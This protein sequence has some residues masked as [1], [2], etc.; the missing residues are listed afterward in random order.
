MKRDMLN[1]TL[2]TTSAGTVTMR[3]PF[4]RMMLCSALTLHSAVD[5]KSACSGR[6]APPGPSDQTTTVQ[7][8]HRPQFKATTGGDG[9]FTIAC[10]STHVVGPTTGSGG[11]DT[12]PATAALNCG[13]QHWLDHT[14][15][16]HCRPRQSYATTGGGGKFTT[17]GVRTHVVGPATGNGG[18]DMVPATAALNC[19]RQHWL[20]HTSR[21]HCRPRDRPGQGRA[22]T[23]GTKQRAGGKTAARGAAF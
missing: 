4:L 15:R 18:V 21:Q 16:Q 22:D 2:T 7:G 1:N 12:V 17:A 14:S 23:I 6:S 5:A 9:N 10:V 11:V 19:G 3:N 20:D 13:R 8:S